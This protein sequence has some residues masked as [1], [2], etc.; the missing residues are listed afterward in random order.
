MSK[1]NIVWKE[2]DGYTEGEQGGWYFR[3][4][5]EVKAFIMSLSTGKITR[6]V[7]GKSG[8]SS[9]ESALASL[10]KTLPGVSKQS[11]NEAEGDR[12]T[13]TVGESLVVITPRYYL[14]WEDKGSVHTSHGFLSIEAAKEEAIV[15]GRTP[16]Q[17]TSQKVVAF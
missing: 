17:K 9:V 14:S 5:G 7:G 10:E 2:L 3:I 6:T 11:F 8:L 1:A 16:H 13:A 15:V 12:L 4:G